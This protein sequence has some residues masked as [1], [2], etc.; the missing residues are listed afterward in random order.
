M[1]HSRTLEQGRKVATRTSSSCS[2]LTFLNQAP[3]RGKGFCRRSTRGVV[4]PCATKQ[5]EHPKA[6]PAASL[7]GL[8]S[9]GSPPTLPGP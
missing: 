7:R 5:K 3:P 6:R 1:V 8:L 9:G 2:F 4:V